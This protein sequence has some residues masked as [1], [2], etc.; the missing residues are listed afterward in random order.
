MADIAKIREEIL[1]ELKEWDQPSIA[2]GIVKD[3]EVVLNEGFGW[4][5]TGKGL[6]ADAETLYQIGSCSKA[7]TAAAAAVLVDQGKIAWDTP[8]REY[9][10]WI[11]FRDPF[12]T[13]NVT[14]RDLLSHRTGLPRHDAYWIDGPCTRREM[15]ENLAN[16][17]PCWSM[18]SM[19]CYQNTCYV[20]AGMVIE[21][22][23][24]MTWEAFVKKYLLD[25]I[26][27]S[28]TDFYVDYIEGDPNHAAP[29]D[30]PLPTDLK[31][32]VEI[33]FLKSDREDRTAGIGAPYGPAGSI[34]STVNDM[35]KW[36][37][38]LLNKGKAGDVQVLSEE[39]VAELTKP[40]MLMSSALLAPLPEED[41]YSYGMG[42]FTETYRG[43]RRAEHGGNINGFSALVTLMPDCA[44]GVV[45]LTNFNNS[46][47]T[48][49]TTHSI[50]DA[51][52]GAGGG[53]WHNRYRELIRQVFTAELEKVKNP[54]IRR[55]EGTKPSHAPQ[56]YAG[57]Y[58]NPT[59]G[60]IVVSEAGGS[61]T[62]LYNK[63]SSP[64]EHYHYDTFRITDPRHLFSGMLLS[65]LL[66]QKG[67]VDR[68]SFG[69]VLNPEAK[70][71]V[72]TRV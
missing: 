41:F 31:G 9:L 1:R 5:D 52:L 57:T 33:P 2:V 38:C 49:A 70:D 46:F 72:F 35:L 45:T 64:L 36:V 51:Y 15:V 71:E 47:N 44:L 6:K 18:R 23:S 32:C 39:S 42:W 16:M 13:A 28:R 50:L 8:V 4:A 7:F 68:I 60:D 24:G 48:Y 30:R 21:A 58:R 53:D 37:S 55:V 12:V 34:M 29:Y 20:A 19:W 40:Q 14:M 10:P 66:N 62:F 17:Q 69:I 27:M 54:E 22:V 11:K 26:G 67:E 63:A 43:R 25:P 59:Y 56:A 65:F 3:G 61:L